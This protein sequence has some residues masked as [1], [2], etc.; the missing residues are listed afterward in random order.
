VIPLQMLL[1]ALRR[2]RSPY[3]YPRAA[4]DALRR[5]CRH[6]RWRSRSASAPIPHLES[7]PKHRET[8][9]LV[10]VQPYSPASQFPICGYRGLGAAGCTTEVADVVRLKL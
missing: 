6:W 8:S 5:T 1:A 4:R 2:E 7:V 9:A 10:I 3:R